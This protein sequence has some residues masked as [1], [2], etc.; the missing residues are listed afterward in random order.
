MSDTNPVFFHVH[1]KGHLSMMLCVWEVTRSTLD[2]RKHKGPS[3]HPKMPLRGLSLSIEVLLK[4]TNR[5]NKNTTTSLPRLI[6]GRM[7]MNL[8]KYTLLYE[9]SEILGTLY[10]APS[11]P[12]EFHVD[13]IFRYLVRLLTLNG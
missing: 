9:T 10:I 7:S 13:L 5:M 11:C 12:S 6:R 4:M 3:S 8:A 2:D 1:L